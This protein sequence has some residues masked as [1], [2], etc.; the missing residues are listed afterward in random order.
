[1]DGPAG[2]RILAD[3][4]TGALDASPYPVDRRFGARLVGRI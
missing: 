2:G 3:L 1:M 4:V